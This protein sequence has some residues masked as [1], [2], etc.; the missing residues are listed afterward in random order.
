MRKISMM[1][2]V[3]S[4]QGM[5]MRKMFCKRVLPSMAAASY[6]VGSMPEMAAV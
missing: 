3:G 2:M 5:V 4:M 6:S 1:A